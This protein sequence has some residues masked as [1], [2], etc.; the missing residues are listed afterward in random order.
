MKRLLAEPSG[1]DEAV[2]AHADLVQRFLCG[3]EFVDAM[4]AAIDAGSIRTS[5]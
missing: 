2:A 1:L 4:I 5:C 3:P